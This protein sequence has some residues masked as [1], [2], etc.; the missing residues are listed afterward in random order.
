MTHRFRRFSQIKLREHKRLNVS[1][2]ICEICGRTAFDFFAIQ[3]VCLCERR[4]DSQTGQGRTGPRITRMS[5]M[6]LPQQL[7]TDHHHK[8]FSLIGFRAEQCRDRALPSVSESSVRSVVHLCFGCGRRP[9][10]GERQKNQRAKKSPLEMARSK[11]PR[12]HFSAPAN[13]LTVE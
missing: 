13:S 12:L 9:Q 4:G 3:T 5:R 7:D 2:E 6:N 1:A 10:P 8:T 11:F